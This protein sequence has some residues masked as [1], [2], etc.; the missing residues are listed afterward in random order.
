MNTMVLGILIVF[1][2][3]TTLLGSTMP[4]L[5]PG[6]TAYPSSQLKHALVTDFQ[7][8]WVWS[9]NFQI[10]VYL[11]TRHWCKILHFCSVE[12]QEKFPMEIFN[13]Y[14]QVL[15][16]TQ[17]K[18]TYAGQILQDLKESLP[19]ITTTWSWIWLRTFNVYWI[20]RA[21]TMHG[22]YVEDSK[23]TWIVNKSISML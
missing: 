3:A 15:K 20:A 11:Q 17:A 19:T 1:W 9:S 23:L 16:S 8:Y 7:L 22:T 21:P 10:T 13:F 12:R 4:C 5:R 2:L 14:L 18:C 6:L